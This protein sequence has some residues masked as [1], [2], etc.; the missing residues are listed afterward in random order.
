MLSQARIGR[1][2]LLWEQK[3]IV[4]KAHILGMVSASTFVFLLRILSVLLVLIIAPQRAMNI[5]PASI[6]PIS[7][8][9]LNSDSICSLSHSFLSY[10]V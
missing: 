1:S 2:E 7:S 10:S 4:I 6:A 9:L 8:C 3:L 5:K